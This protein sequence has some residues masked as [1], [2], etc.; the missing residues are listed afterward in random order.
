M[1][2]LAILTLLCI[3]CINIHAQGISHSY[4]RVPLTTILKELDREQKGYDI[5]FIYD[6]LR[7]FTI[8]TNVKAKNVVDAIHQIIGFYP[9]SVNVTDSTI[10]VECG[11]TPHRLNGQ[12]VDE[13]NKPIEYA[14]IAIFASDGITL[15]AGGVSDKDGR[16]VVPYSPSNIVVRISRIDKKTIR[17]SVSNP[18]M[19]TVRMVTDT[20][21]LKEIVVNERLVKHEAGIDIVN[22]MQLRKGKTDLVDLLKDVPGLIVTDENIAIPGKGSVKV[23][24]NGREKRLPVSQLGNILKTY[25][26]SNVAKIEIIREPDAKFDAE[27][28]F[29]VINIITEKQLDYVGGSIGNTAYY[30]KKWRNNL[31]G[32]VNYQS[33]RI[34][35]SVNGGWVYGKSPYDESSVVDYSTMTR[36]SQTDFTTQNNAYS[37]IGSLDIMLDSL[38]TLGLEVSYSSVKIKQ[39]GDGIGWTYGDDGSLQETEYSQDRKSGPP[40][41]NLNLNLFIDRNWSRQKSISF[42]MDVFRFKQES[43]YLF[44]TSYADANGAMLDKTDRVLNLSNRELHGA[45]GAIDFKTPLPWGIKLATGL[46]ATISTTDNGLH[47]EYSSLPVQDNDFTYNEDI[48]AAYATLTK[49][50]GSVSL[51]I[52]GRYEFTHTKGEPQDG[53]ATINDYGRFYPNIVASYNYGKGSTLELSSRSGIN[54]PGLRALNP[55][56]EYVNSYSVATGNPS[57]EPSYWYNIQLRNTLG[58]MGGEFSSSLR[59]ARAF[60]IIQQVFEMDADSGTDLS[61]WRNAYDK[62]GGYLDLQ[63]YLTGVKWMRMNLLTELVYEQSRRRGDI[64]LPN[65]TTFY[66]YFFG[67]FRFFLDKKHNLSTSINGSYSGREHNAHGFVEKQYNVNVSA[68]YSCL[69]DKLNLNLGIT[70]LIASHHKGVSYSNDNMTFRFDNDYSYRCIS[71]GISYRL[72]KDIRTKQKTHSNTDIKGRF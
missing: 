72:G 27:G 63:L 49:N 11:E 68:S 62:D 6:D 15:I 34:T 16:F 56:R 67:S 70:S 18:D 60:K 30:N 35:A 47:Y 9:I 12:L 14:N 36:K 69:N 5:S 45:S 24:F 48:Y 51:R 59:Y 50:I 54:R 23:M 1:T 29:G 57:I 31:R 64:G 40:L 37:A 38:S 19:G 71:F 44:N 43:D 33:G 8:T 10:L 13:K 61:Q 3:L 26:A 66:P 7:D 41:Q 20:K 53:D 46:K 2:R 42:V 17:R 39:R 4:D 22:T 55:F 32:N 52:G 65:E 28:N 21:V 25:Q 58:F